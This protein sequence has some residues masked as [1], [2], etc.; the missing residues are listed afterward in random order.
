MEENRPKITWRNWLA[1][2]AAVVLT[3]AGIWGIS[4]LRQKPSD[5]LL[6]NVVLGVIGV[7]ILGYHLRQACLEEELDY[8]NQAH[9]F[10]FWLSYAAGLAVSFAC[11]F[12]PVSA[13]PYL[14]VFLL[15]TLFSNMSTGIL[16]ASVLLTFSV[17]LAGVSANIFLVY[18]LSGVFVATLFRHLE[19]DFRIGGRLFLSLLCLL[20]CE[21]AQIILP[22]NDR[23]GIESFVIP[24][25]N[26][27]LSG[28]LLII[29][30]KLFS[31]VVVYRFRERYLELNDT[32]NPLLGE[33]RT[34][35]REAYMHSI[36][37]AYFCERIASRLSLNTE[38]LKCAAY[39]HR[40][41]AE[42]PQIIDEQPF[43]PEVRAVLTEYR[44]RKEEPIRKKETAVL[45]CADT[46]MDT[47]QRL[48]IRSEGHVLNYD[49][50]I[51]SVFR[52]FDEEDTFAQCDITLREIRM[53][54][55]IFKEEKLYYDFLR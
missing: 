9:C 23:P 51:E 31:S 12:L 11:A 4:L 21:T 2:A 32:E 10:R 41:C 19:A 20:L 46:V 39:Y 50:I 28:I 15:L 34:Q 52:H 37:T 8:D 40:L 29:I 16:A 27:I 42:K 6:G 7:S 36:H 48:V 5:E 18:F 33:Y 17:A 43:P 24:A 3:I 26:V 55:D 14:P 35:S 1:E 25:V 30:L 45:L 13:W 47:V 38:L 49:Y 44:N 22:A 54:R 53:M